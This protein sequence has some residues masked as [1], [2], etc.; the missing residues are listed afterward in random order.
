M[1]SVGTRDISKLRKQGN[2]MAKK[3]QSDEE[4]FRD[5]VLEALNAGVLD[6]YLV[7]V[8]NSVQ[9]RA[10]YLVQMDKDS[11]KQQQTETN[12]A[13][14]SKNPMPKRNN[15]SKKKDRSVKDTFYTVA[16]NKKL[17][18]AM[19]RVLSESKKDSNNSIVE[20]VQGVEGYPEGKKLSVKTS[21][22][23]ETG[24]GSDI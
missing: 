4:Q 7:E 18:G 12:S 19:V 5:M 9:Q 6:E 10:N 2:D 13:A 24:I 1:Q 8:G 22:L 23:Q 14:V 20:V 16:R 15:S 3:Q 17:S 11:Q 21:N